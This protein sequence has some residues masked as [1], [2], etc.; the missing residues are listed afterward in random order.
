VIYVTAKASTFDSGEQKKSTLSTFIS[1]YTGKSYPLNGT[2]V[3][4]G[5]LKH[6]QSIEKLRLQGKTEQQI[7]HN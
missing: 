4:D 1:P 3:Y 2:I 5:L 7:C 6:Q